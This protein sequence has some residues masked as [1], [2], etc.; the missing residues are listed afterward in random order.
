MSALGKTESEGW[1]EV[2]LQ[3]TSDWYN[4]VS[5]QVATINRLYNLRERC[6]RQLSHRVNQGQSVS[7]N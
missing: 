7:R 6:L 4:K 5:P 1:W 3:G 2:D